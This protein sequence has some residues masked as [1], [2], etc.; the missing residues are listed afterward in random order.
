METEARAINLK[1]A[2]ELLNLKVKLLQ[3]MVGEAFGTLLFSE[4]NVMAL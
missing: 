4:C 2:V 1:H 3:L